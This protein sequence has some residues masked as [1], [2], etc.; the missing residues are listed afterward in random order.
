MLNM[1]QW[2]CR[3]HSQ[4]QALFYH[5]PENHVNRKTGTAGKFVKE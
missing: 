4:L 3:R 2:T 5:S 1:F